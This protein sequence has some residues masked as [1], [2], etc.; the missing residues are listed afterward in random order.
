MNHGFPVTVN[1]TGFYRRSLARHLVSSTDVTRDDGY[2][3]KRANERCRR[4]LDGS[5]DAAPSYVK[6]ATSD[7]RLFF[8][9]GPIDVRFR[10]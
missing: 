8:L 4:I 2:V 3:L 1:H 7:Q 5:R 9:I 6:C 10:F